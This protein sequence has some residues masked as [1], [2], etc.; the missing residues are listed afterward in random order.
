[1]ICIFLYV[2][3]FNAT[4]IGGFCFS[5]LAWRLEKENWI[6][7]RQRLYGERQRQ[8]KP[9]PLRG[10]RL[11][12]LL[13][14]ET[15]ECTFRAAEPGC[16]ASRTFWTEQPGCSWIRTGDDSCTPLSG[17]R[18]CKRHMYLFS[19]SSSSC[20]FQRLNVFCCSVHKDFW[21]WTRRYWL[22][23]VSF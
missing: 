3:K 9:V 14:S 12:R 2:C 6:S 22:K 11:S 16:T 7:Y 20:S 13:L 23:E 18:I 8:S 21:D 15:R 1:M 4:I 17:S 5:L 19:S 10:L